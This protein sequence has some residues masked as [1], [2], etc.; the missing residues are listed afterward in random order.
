MLDVKIVGTVAKKE[1]QNLIIGNNRSLANAGP[2][3][4]VLPLHGSYIMIFK[5]A[6]LAERGKIILMVFAV[7]LNNSK[8]LNIFHVSKNDFKNLK[9]VAGTKLDRILSFLGLCLYCILLQST[10]RGLGRI[11]LG[12]MKCRQL[13][14]HPNLSPHGRS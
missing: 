13:I 11:E 6:T 10:S 8:L 4:P 9:P 14:L 12:S 7:L 2:T 3:F 5:P 1:P